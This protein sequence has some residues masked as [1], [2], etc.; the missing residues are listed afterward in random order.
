MYKH[1]A[2]K[3]LSVKTNAKMQELLKIHYFVL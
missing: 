2:A 3:T 1:F